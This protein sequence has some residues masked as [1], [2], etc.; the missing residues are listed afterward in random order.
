MF[1]NF[2]EWIRK[3][4]RRVTEA[5][6]YDISTPEGKRRANWHALLIDHGFLRILWTNLYEVTPGVWRSNQP[7]RKRL[8]KYKEMGIKTII[9]LRGQSA[10]GFYRFEKRG[11]RR[12]QIQLLNVRMSARQLTSREELLQLLDYFETAQRPMLMHCKSG[13]DRAGLASALYL[14]HIENTPIEDAK[15]QLSLRY[16]HIRSSKTG[17]LDFML[18]AYAID[19]RKTPMPIRKWIEQQYDRETLTAKFAAARG[20]S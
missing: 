9:N 4:E 19:T 10:S 18:D 7:D 14:L 11:C 20:T 13:A 17:I 2:V 12:N 15:K 5:W 3:G 1:S 16:A 8:T 6:A